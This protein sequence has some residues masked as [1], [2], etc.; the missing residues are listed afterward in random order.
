MENNQQRLDFDRRAR[1]NRSR[2]NL[3]R[4]IEQLARLS[5]CELTNEYGDELAE[6]WKEYDSLHSLELQ[7]IN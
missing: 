5:V 3:R 6:R 1:I 2:L 7:I 4:R